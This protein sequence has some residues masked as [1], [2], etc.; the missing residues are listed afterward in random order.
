VE[1]TIIKQLAGVLALD[2]IWVLL[3]FLALFVYK[4]LKS[5]QEDRK[6]RRIDTLVN[7]KEYFDLPTESREIFIKELLFENHFGRLLSW[8]DISFFL[9]SSEPI[10]FLKMYMT[11]SKHLHL[12]RD[13]GKIHLKAS[14]SPNRIYYLNLFLY[15]LFGVPALLMLLGAHQAFG[16][17]GPEL[18][19]P[20]T[21]VTMCLVT[22]SALFLNEGMSIQTATRLV[23]ELNA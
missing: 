19:A 9:T 23:R 4:Q 7:I 3:A 12:N 13:R 6:Q 8:K 18:Y 11:C 21:I 17:S 1:A 14:I 2:A 10:R 22:M 15:F 5:R 20:W 16:I